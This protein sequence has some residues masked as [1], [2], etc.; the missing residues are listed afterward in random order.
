MAHPKRSRREYSGDGHRVAQGGRTSFAGGSVALRRRRARPLAAPAL[1][2]V[3][4]DGTVHTKVDDL[5][6]HRTGI[7]RVD[8]IDHEDLIVRVNDG[9]GVTVFTATMA[10]EL[11]GSLFSSR[12]RYTRGWA[13][14]DGQWRIV[15]AHASANVP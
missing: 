11:A 9:V 8:A 3:G 6:W 12:M 1:V 10:G 15:V 14:S 13:W 5:E 2:F 4:P 7:L